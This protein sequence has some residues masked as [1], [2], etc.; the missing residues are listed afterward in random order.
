MGSRPACAGRGGG[1]GGAGRA[2]R[3]A[4]ARGAAAEAEIFDAHLLF[5][6]DEA[7]LEPA[8]SAIFE[9][10]ANAAAAWDETVRATAE[11]W[12]SLD[13]DYLSARAEDVDEVGRRVL[14]HLLEVDAAAPVL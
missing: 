2:R 3:W 9:R 1:G 11:V 13:D 7:L 10:R 12:R 5:L 8:R 4:A 14:A 6:R